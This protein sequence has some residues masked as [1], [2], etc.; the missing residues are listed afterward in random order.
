MTGGNPRKTHIGH[1]GIAQTMGKIAAINMIGKTP[2]PL[3]AIPFFFTMQYGKG[4]RF[5]GDT[6]GGFGEVIIQG[7]IDNYKYVAYYVE[8]N[9][10]RIVACSTL[11]M[12]PIASHFAQLLGSGR[13]LYKKDV[14]ADSNA[15]WASKL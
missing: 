7:D 8:K 3:T 2:K 9:G 11:G 5:A 12:D 6:N 1:W 10:T 13:Q 4:I 15:N 14:E